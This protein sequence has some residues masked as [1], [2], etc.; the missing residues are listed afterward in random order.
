METTFYVSR[1]HFRT[2]EGATLVAYIHP[3]SGDSRIQ[4]LSTTAKSAP[5][6]IVWTVTGLDD[7]SEEKAGRMGEHNWWPS[8]IIEFLTQ[9]NKEKR[10]ESEE[11]AAENGITVHNPRFP[12]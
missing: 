10:V 8:D 1:Q 2:V 11:K 3:V 9:G 6:H 5:C 4:E 12:K 7:W